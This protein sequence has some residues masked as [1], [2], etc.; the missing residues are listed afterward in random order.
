MPAKARNKIAVNTKYYVYVLSLDGATNQVFYVGKGTDQRIIRHLEEAESS[1]LCP[2]CAVIRHLT[3]AN[4]PYWY[5]IVLETNDEKYALWYEM[6]AITA[7]PYGSLCNQLGGAEPSLR[8][9][10]TG[11]SGSR[12]DWEC[13][14]RRLRPDGTTELVVDW[15]GDK[16]EILQRLRKVYDR[17]TVDYYLSRI[18]V[19]VV[20]PDERG[21]S[22]PYRVGQIVGQRALVS[23]V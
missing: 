1:H 21:T 18:G 9:I 6:Q 22:K 11:P 7:F 2:K 3:K 14:L 17:E 8:V 15:G 10:W 16:S 12:V 23:Q 20:L 4:K 5:H 19:G 13:E